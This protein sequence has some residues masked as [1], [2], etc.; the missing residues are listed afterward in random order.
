MADSVNAL[1]ITR[2]AW[3]LVAQRASVPLIEVE[4]IC[5]DRAEQ[6][7]RIESRKPDVQGLAPSA[8]KAVLERTYEAWSGPH[9]IIDTAYKS[10]KEAERELINHLRLTNTVTG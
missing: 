2:G 7:R 10:V 8:W 9:I 3:A 6:R 5:S 1:R 4:V